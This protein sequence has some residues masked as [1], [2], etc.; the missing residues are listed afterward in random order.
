MF[1]VR[2]GEGL[3]TTLMA[4]YLMF[5]LFAY[6]ILKPVSRALLLTNIDIE[7]LPWVYIRDCH[8]GRG[9]RV[10]LYQAGGTILAA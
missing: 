2:K 5:V 6:Y 9:A 1:D 3:K 8:R 7:K 10:L 4:L